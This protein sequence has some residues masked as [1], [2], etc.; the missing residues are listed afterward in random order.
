MGFA[1]DSGNGRTIVTLPLPFA[2]RGGVPGGV[3]L[4]PR[5]GLLEIPRVHLR[6][7][8]DGR[9]GHT[10]R[11]PPDPPL[12]EER[13]HARLPLPGRALGATL[14]AGAEEH[15]LRGGHCELIFFFIF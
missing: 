13:H 1:R 7:D 15:Q 4:S 14:P 10:A 12:P 11:G 3:R 5:T 8:M 6:R 2:D 9:A